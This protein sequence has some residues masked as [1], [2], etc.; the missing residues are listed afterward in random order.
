[1]IDLFGTGGFKA[2]T[3]ALDMDIFNALATSKMSAA[4]LAE[5]V[6]ADEHGIRT[7]LTLLE[8]H[9]YV[10]EDDG[11]YRCT[12]TT[13]KWLTE[14]SKTNMG[15]FLTFWDEL[16]FPFWDQQLETAIREGEPSQT[17]FEWFDEE[18]ARWE[19]AQRGFRAAASVMV[20]EVADKITVPKDATD[21]LDVGGGHGLYS[22][23]LCRRHSNLSATIF[24]NPEALDIAREEIAEADLKDRMD[25]QGGD[26]WTD[27]M[28]IGNDLALLFN[29][30]HI[31]NAKENTRLF[32][33]VA[34]TLEPGGR[35][36]LL[37]QLE[38]S[39]SMPVGQA[40]LGFLG[41]TYLV[42]VGADI[43]PYTDVEKWLHNAGFE[44]VQKKSIRRAGPGNMLIEATKDTDAL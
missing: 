15:P 31:N 2:V 5:T 21:V 9:G 6:D 28:G 42:T 11:Q 44:N 40:A 7:L 13:T 10:T 25:T 18:P 4:R 23:E 33:R 35:I 3:M 34:T 17:M 41:M 37:D 30:I 12:A 19:T 29:V 1:M 27:D 36:V 8:S 32:E 14:D 26:Y 16:V 39:S 24:D 38:G 22:I 43:H 20:D